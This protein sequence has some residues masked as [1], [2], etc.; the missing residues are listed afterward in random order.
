MPVFS[1]GTFTD[2]LFP[3]PEHRRM[4]ERLKS[5]NADYPVQ[6][7]Y[8]DYNHFVQNKRKEWADVCGDDVCEPEDYPGGDLNAAPNGR[9]LETGPTTRLNAFLDHYAK[10][11]GNPSQGAPARDVTGALQVCPS[12]A[13]ALGRAEDEPGP[14]FSAATFAQLAPNRLQVSAPGNQSTTNP[15]VPNLHAKNA[16]P[17]GNLAT[18]GGACPAEQSPGGLATA[19]PG[20]ATY[21]SQTLTRTFTMLGQTRVTV[22]HTGTGPAGQLN[23]RLYDLAP[24]GEQVMVDRGVKRITGANGTTTF[25]LHGAGWR[26]ASGHKLRLEVTQDDE[27][28][29]KASTLPSSLTLSGATMS[30]PVREASGTV[31]GGPGPRPP[32]SG[33]GGSQGGSNNGSPGAGSGGLPRCASFLRA[34]RRHDL[35]RRRRLRIRVGLRRRSRIAAVVRRRGLRR[36]AR[37]SRRANAGR[38]LITLKVSRLA[39][40]GRHRLKVRIS[41]AGRRPQTVYRRV[42]F[43]P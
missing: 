15:A 3:A 20:V 5:T 42:R 6:E 27:P 7:Y 29:L 22:A 39:R 25:D 33:G 32:G 12:N 24:D 14:R 34:T 10:P 1:A 35:S 41:C 23:A 13:S 18:N 11:P 26:F 4:V 30:V 21:D 17:V 19:G 37:T 2:K 16:D 28:Y 31:G 40:P 36:W 9:T 43:V 8:G 38:K